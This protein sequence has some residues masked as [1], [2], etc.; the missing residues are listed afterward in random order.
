M[1]KLLLTLLFNASA[2]ITQAQNVKP[3]KEETIKFINIILKNIEGRII[4]NNEYTYTWKNIL[5]EEIDKMNAYEDKGGSYMCLKFKY[6]FP[7]KLD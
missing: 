3:T 2:F 5:W 4:Y 6:S 7:V 1:K